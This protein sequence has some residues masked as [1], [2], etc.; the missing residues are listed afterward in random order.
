MVRRV[1]LA[2]AGGPNQAARSAESRRVG[3]PTSLTATALAL[4]CWLSTPTPSA[5]AQP[6]RIAIEARLEPSD[7]TISGHV[8]ILLRND[9][10]Q[11]LHELLFHLYPN[12]FSSDDTVFMKQSGGQLRGVSAADQD[13]GHLEVESLTVNGISV[14]EGANDELVAGDHTQLQVPLAT[15]LPV[16]SSAILEITFVTQLPPLFARSGY[17]GDFHI[18]AQFF[19]KL[20]KLEPDGTWAGFPYYGNGEFYADFARYELTVDVPDGW[21]VGATGSM[22][23]QRT[24]GSR[25]IYVFVADRVHDA[26]FVTAPFLQERVEREGDV[27]IRVLYPPGYGSAVERHLYVTRRG[28][29]HFGQMLGPYAYDDLT[30]VVPPRGAEGGAGMEYPTLF[31]TAGS[32]LSLPSLP[33]V[34]QDEVTAHELGHQ[35]FQGM[36][37]TN[38]AAH[39]MLDEGLTEW[40]TGDLMRAMHG[41]DRSGIGIPGLLIDSFE[42]RRVWAFSGEDTPPPSSHVSDFKSQGSYGRAVYARSASVLETVA[43]TWGRD[44]LRQALGRYARRHRFGHPV[45]ADLYRAFDEVYGP[46]MSARVLRPALEHNATAEVR[47]T[48][49]EPAEDQTGLTVERWG[50][51]PIPTSLR[52]EREDGSVERVPPPHRPPAL[53]WEARRPGA[54]CP[55]RRGPSITTRP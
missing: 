14:L 8:T 50:T 18:G 49:F 42:I 9:T 54:K 52:V 32:W 29:R 53:P 15:P 12:A 6:Q 25:R 34:A 17:A 7:H 22:K 20:A 16:G 1:S 55:H 36:I 46:W 3:L 11:P 47:I 10:A 23:E 30:V 13:R 39:P 24:E 27:R 2:N 45:P 4:A 40:I 37:A 21:Q 51:L 33:I 41:R 28:L 44:R 26:A 48:R 19:P 35:W 31:I 43:R 5:L 38:E